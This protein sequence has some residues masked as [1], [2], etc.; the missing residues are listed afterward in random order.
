MVNENIRFV[1][2]TR[3]GRDEFFA[4][5]PLGK[6]LALYRHLLPE[7]SLQITLASNN[8]AGLPTVYNSAIE[9]ARKKPAVLIF[10]HDDIHLCDFY[11][12]HHIVQGLNAFPIIGLA[13]GTRR[14]PGQTTWWNAAREVRPN[15]GTE[16]HLSGIVGHGKGFP[17]MEQVSC[18]GSPGQEV[19]LLDGL[20]LAARSTTLIDH[21]LRFDPR[22]RFHFYDL[23]FCRQAEIKQVKMGTWPISVIH[24]S[25]GNYG[26][27]WRQACELYLDKYGETSAA[28]TASSNRSR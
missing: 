27:A 12:P 15:S 23:D 9:A 14:V 26:P 1:C 28:G 3:M 2:A 5:A 13:G 8:K 19:K 24:E 11:W 17:N 22:F 20:F 25:I 6:S 10:A 16:R 7:G 4:R 18:F 21:D